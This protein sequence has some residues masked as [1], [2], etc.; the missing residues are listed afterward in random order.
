M[1]DLLRPAA[2][3]NVSYARQNGASRS[4]TTTLTPYTGTWSRK[5]AVHLLKRTMFGAKKADVDHLLTLT[6]SQAVDELLTAPGSPPSPPVNNYNNASFT[7]A[8]IAFGQT[9]VNDPTVQPNALGPRAASLKAWW[10]GQMIN[11]P[12]S[13]EEKL[14]LF[15]H[16]HFS[17]QL[18]SYVEPRGGYKYLATIRQYGLGNFKDFVKAITLDPAMLFFL[19]GY[20]N[21]ST[22]P[23]ENYAREL[24]ELFTVGKDLP[25]HY[26]E[27]DVRAAARVLTGYRIDPSTLAV[28]F[29][30]AQHDTTDKQF[31]SFYNN[32][33]ITGQA[34]ANGANELDDLLTMIFA[35]QETA[36]YICRQIYRFF[37]YFDIDATIETNIIIPL[38][39]DFRTNGYQ[40]QPILAKLFKSEHFYDMLNRG[41]IIKSPTDFLIGLLREYNVAFPAPTAIADSYQAW[42]TVGY[43]SIV[44]GQ[45]ILDPPS[46]S[47]WQSYYQYPQYYELWINNSTLPLR[48][49]ITDALTYVG[50]PVNTFTVKIDVLDYCS[51]LP[52]PSDPVAVVNDTIDLLYMIDVSQTSKDGIRIYGLLGGQTTNGYW[53]T[54]WTDY[55]NDP[56][57]V[58]KKNIVETRLQ[59]FF[60]YLMNLSEYHLA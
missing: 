10:Y 12:R 29:V 5:E 40:I 19:N 53:T 59:G 6:M 48:N 18:A 16:N 7:D 3:P 46:V 11:Q 44:L 55:V 22:A 13:I 8:A 28:S 27:D 33:L 24:Q 57:N 32:T 30:A 9:W 41:C 1:N 4:S 20:L 34:G 45:D 42:L 51:N 43:Y 14:V 2:D 25:S 49:Q 50:A 38:A 58:T 36:K 39:N 52:N 60:K 21:T 31:S 37:V 17:T 54:A 23:D 26:T 15:W 56:T 35:Q 47:G